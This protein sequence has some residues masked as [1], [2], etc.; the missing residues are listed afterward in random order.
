MKNGLIGGT[1]AWLAVA[2]WLAMAGPAAAGG[3]MSI[4]AGMVPVLLAQQQ[5]P[6]DELDQPTNPNRPGVTE[7]GPGEFWVDFEE[8][9]LKE[10]VEAI[11]AK[12]GRNFFIDPSVGPQSVTVVS[13]HP[14]PEEMALEVLE[15][16]LDAYG[17]AMYPTLEGNLIRIAQRGTG[18]DKLEVTSAGET[19]MVGFERFAIHVVPVQ[20]TDASEVSELL[21]AVGSQNAQIRVYAR[22]NT[23]LLIDTVSGIRNMLEVLEL[24]DVPGFEVVYEIFRLQFSRAEILAQQLI[25][26][27]EDTA[28]AT[29]GGAANQMSAAARI[30]AARAAQAGAGPDTAVVG[31]GGE[32]LRIVPDERLNA[33]IVVASAPMME[34][35]RRFVQELDIPTPFDANNMH[36]IELLYA[37]A[38]QVQE[39]LDALVSA[40]SP[41]GA[42]EGAAPE[43][44]QPF[45]R[46]VFITPYEQN[47]ALLIVASPQDFGILREMITNLDRPRKQVSVQAIILSVTITDQFEWA[48]ESAGLGE[49]DFLALSNVSKIANA[50]VDPLSLAGA[51]GVLGILNETTT[52]TT[53]IPGE[54]GGFVETEVANIPLLISALEGLTDAE[55][56]SQ[57]NLLTQDNAEATMIVGQEVPVLNSLSDV[58]DRTGFQTRGSISREDVGVQL[59]VT[60]QINEGDTVRLEI[61]V[62]VSDTV[63][64]TVGVDPNELGP[65]FQ[66]SEFNN[67][68]VIRNTQTGIIGG[69]IRENKSRVRTQT[70]VIGDL[71]L[72]GWLF[73][74]KR[75]NRSKQNLVVMVTPRI[76][77]EMEELTDITDLQLE[78]FY[79]YNRDVILEDLGFIKKQRK[80]NW[81]RDEYS[82]VSRY[83][84]E[85]DPAVLYFKGRP[86]EDPPVSKGVQEEFE[87]HD[88][89]EELIP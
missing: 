83:N 57:P 60:P 48:V 28:D 66:K 17:L 59:T 18:T 21:Q 79:D 9:S 84:D 88:E 14:V 68:V 58:D 23:L 31:G 11:G 87:D 62:E 34:Q 1:A 85:A 27:L 3:G 40:T 73:R 80:K 5:Q 4:M 52:I 41:R 42:G 6:V 7:A 61:D 25:S 38:E 82:P 20:Y 16:I 30:R 22:T 63:D 45:E 71:P 54:D 32:T 78:Q 39:A 76:V 50:I 69:L 33:L 55:V 43:E 44:I 24:V 29:G 49:D 35:V 65:T 51:G 56:L 2:A 26:V 64:S 67:E 12:T 77:R 72:I 75:N 15:A 86:P 46:E 47:N 19:P 81:K 53:S 13:H 36:Y 70:P 10:V 74:A 37:D 89:I 8:A